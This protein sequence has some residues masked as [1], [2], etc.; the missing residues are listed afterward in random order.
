MGYAVGAGDARVDPKRALQTCRQC[1]LQPLCRVHERLDARIDTDGCPA[2]IDRRH[3]EAHQ[4]SADG[5]RVLHRR[6]VRD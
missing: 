2:H 5:E 3:T 6:A 1:D 4:A